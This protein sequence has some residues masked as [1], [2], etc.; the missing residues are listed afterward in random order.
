[1]RSALSDHCSRH[2]VSWWTDR[3]AHE[4]EWQR[5]GQHRFVRGGEHPPE[6]QRP[7]TGRRL[8][9]LVRSNMDRARGVVATCALPCTPLPMTPRFILRSLAF[10]L[11]RR[12]PSRTMSTHRALKCEL[13]RSLPFA[14]FTD[15]LPRT[16]TVVHKHAYF[17]FAKFDRS[18]LF[19]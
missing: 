9:L 10:Q 12:C 2:A 5:K 6:S 19:V 1:M 3:P 15:I 7:T 17:M 14:S 13:Q 8:P 4:E 16:F 18:L 11:Y